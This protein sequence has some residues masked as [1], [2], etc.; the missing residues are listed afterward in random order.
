MGV[1]YTEL[2]HNFGYLM[3]LCFGFG[4][5][6]PYLEHGIAPDRARACEPENGGE[7][8]SFPSTIRRIAIM[9]LDRP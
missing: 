5:L 6:L 7:Y 1:D 4:S 2:E 3:E 9:L 8:L